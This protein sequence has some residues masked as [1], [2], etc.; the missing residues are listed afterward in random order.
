VEKE[1]LKPEEL[2]KLSWVQ[3][4]ADLFGGGG[5]GGKITRT[6]PTTG[7]GGGGGNLGHRGIGELLLFRKHVAKIRHDEGDTSDG[8]KNNEAH[9]VKSRGYSPQIK[10]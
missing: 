9:T 6:S 2:E 7:G 3:W 4:A 8:R 1:A 5:S 10:T